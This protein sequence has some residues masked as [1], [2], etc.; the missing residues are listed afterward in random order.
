MRDK[1]KQVSDKYKSKLKVVHINAQSLNNS[2]HYCEFT[3]AF[4]NSEIDIIAVS[5]TFFQENSRTELPNYKIF[6]IN[7]VGRSGGGVALYVKHNLKASLLSKSNG[8]SGEPEYVII[9]V[10]FG[11]ETLLV[12]CVYRPPKI[13]YLETFLD[14]MYYLLPNF[15]Y[16]IICGDFNARFGSGSYESKLVKELF[17][18]CDHTCIPYEATFHTEHCDSMLD[19]IA[20]NFNEKIIEY[21][22]CAAPA[23]S[24]H[25]LIYV[26]ANFSIPPAKKKL[27]KYR[28]FKNIDEVALL[29]DANNAPWHEVYDCSDIDSKVEKFNDIFLELIDKHAP[30]KTFSAKNNAS[31]WMNNEIRRLIDLR[32]KSR[33][34]FLKSKATQD[35]GVYKSLRNKTK[36]EI[37]NAKIR[38][39]HEIFKDNQSPNKM[40]ANIR[41][42]GIGK[43]KLNV[44][45]FPVTPND[46]N[47][48]YLNVSKIENQSLAEETELMYSS[49]YDFNKAFHFKFVTA[50]EIKNII[51][52]I[53]S[54][55]VGVDGVSIKFLKLILDVVM[56]VLEHIFNYCLQSSVFPS[57]W[58][59]ANVLP[60]PKVSNPTKC[61]DFRPV[62]ILCILSKA[63]EKV[64]HDQ[65]Y[66]YAM[67]NNLFNPH[68]S[69]FRKGHSTVTALLKIAD[70]IRK[71]IDERKLTLLVLLDFSKA[72]DRVNHNLL[73]VKLKKLGCS[74]S[75][76]N[77]FKQYL[78]NRKQRVMSGDDFVSDWNFVETGVPQGSVLGPLLFVLYLFDISSVLVHTKCHLYADDTQ[79]YTNFHIDNV[80]DAVK[81]VNDDLCNLVT[82][83]SSHNLYLNVAKTQPIIIG[84]GQYINRLKVTDVPQ[85]VINDISVP[86]C[87]EVT[88]LGVI[89][90]STLSWRQHSTNVIRK[91]FSSLAQARRSFD[92]LPTSVRIRIVQCLI[93]PQIDYGSLLFTDMSK[94]LL[95]KLQKA[96]N[97]CIRFCTNASRFEH[98][99]PYY[100]KLGLLKLVDRRVV[101]NASLVWKVIKKNQPEY[102]REMFKFSARHC[103]RLVIPQHRTSKYSDSFCVTSCRI[104]ND[105][106]IH[107]Y[108]H[109]VTDCA[110]KSNIKKCVSATYS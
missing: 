67:Q 94:T 13:G 86:Y 29:E 97:A 9:E 53:K 18:K 33:D 73:L 12:S 49:D 74:I 15:N 76:V 11:N 96:E 98:I 59:C 7:R 17:E 85:I 55:A 3:D 71:A 64:V 107:N 109:C 39:Y 79:I 54:N 27:I 52:G 37:R 22:Q 41:S 25:D 35:F 87:E 1:L 32:D 93:L 103:D 110:L 60:L 62:S 20:S 89:F 2:G 26:V 40:W 24:N 63:L 38:Y 16:S 46:L 61:A 108:L 78:S 36:Q 77:W 99:T 48:H 104:Y 19:V 44:N 50:L 31:P 47:N 105:Y 101:F 84:S 23:F 10:K 56:Y 70:D 66:E 65:L 57:V 43:A 83:V 106:H 92:C 28:D 95:S 42:L 100:V 21:G 5:E 82:Y 81:L 102:L 6:N 75:V 80:S 45:D 51:V 14:E 90:D 68:Q 58:K 91:V 30:V 4:S 34:K 72:F 69:G 8:E 88:N